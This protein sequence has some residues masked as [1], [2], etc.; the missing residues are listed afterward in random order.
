[1]K[2]RLRIAG[3]AICA[4]LVPA[5]ASVPSESIAKRPSVMPPVPS[6]QV[7][8]RPLSLPLLAAKNQPTDDHFAA[9]RAEATPTVVQRPVAVTEAPLPW[10]DAKP[11]GKSSTEPGPTL[12]TETESKIVTLP[13]P[14]EI[15]PAPV[16]TPPRLPSPPRLTEPEKPRPDPV[17]DAEGVIRANWPV[18]KGTI[19]LDQ[20]PSEPLVLPPPS[21]LIP[22]AKSDEA[23]ADP[24]PS[25]PKLPP[26]VIGSSIPHQSNASPFEPS[27]PVL[28]PPSLESVVPE[29]PVSPAAAPLSHTDD[30]PIIR[31]M[32]S[33]QMNRPDDAV[34]HLKTYDATSQQLLMALLPPI[35]RL[36]EGN[37]N[38]MKP[39]EMDILLEQLSRVPNVIRTRASLQVNNLRLCREVH[40]FAHVEPFPNGHQFRPGDIV[41][42]YMELAN[43]SCTPSANGGYQVTIASGL[44][45]RDAAGKIVWRADPKEVPDSVSTPPHDYYRN[46]RLSVPNVAPGA[47]TL[48]IKTTD[49]PTNREVVR[50]IEMRIGT[51]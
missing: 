21:E 24:V 43:F 34:E 4:C 29:A 30:N 8:S 42:L 50:T 26:G 41:Y 27:A 28:P 44:E 32:R 47:Y 3:T 19:A 46:F 7:A 13:G 5:C 15:A 45:M 12:P 49:R 31:A 10:D 16:V 18:I 23:A 9:N 38:Q 17:P 22:P 36:S 51:R 25:P 2:R 14:N 33:L 6:K 37:L 20:E 1:M 48:S 11:V 35:V 40:N 39:E